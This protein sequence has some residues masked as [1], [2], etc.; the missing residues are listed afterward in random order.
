MCIQS[1]LHLATE[2]QDEH[3]SDSKHIGKLIARCGA[4]QYS[5]GNISGTLIQHDFQYEGML[6]N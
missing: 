2:S 5:N 1:D 6:I 3:E 4:I